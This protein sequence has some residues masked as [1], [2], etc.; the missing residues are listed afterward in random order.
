[1]VNSA[2]NPEL[3]TAAGHRIDVTAHLATAMRAARVSGARAVELKSIPFVGQIGIRA[4]LGSP[5]SKALEASLGFALPTQVGS[6]TFG[7][8]KFAIWQS[9]DEFLVVTDPSAGAVV[10][11]GDQ[12]AALV[13]ALGDNPGSVIDL[14]ANRIV[15]E[16][17]GPAARLVLEKG[18]AHD[19]HPRVFGP[20]TAVQT[21]IG[22]V[23]V[24]IWKHDADK[25]YVLARSSFAD[26]LIHWLVDGMHEFA[27]PEVKPWH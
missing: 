12:V 16:L 4:K 3:A 11:A 15:L 5:S 26:Y 21:A 24:I 19:L 9:P 18:C 10:D 14:S 1:M 2:T 7:K 20:G 27:A 23:P 8:R 22:K 6:V 13:D 17:S 25:F